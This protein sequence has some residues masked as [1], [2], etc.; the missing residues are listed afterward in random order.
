MSGETVVS[1]SPDG[2]TSPATYT[3]MSRTRGEFL[4]SLNR[5]LGTNPSDDDTRDEIEAT[6]NAVASLRELHA[7]NRG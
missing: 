4:R 2:K 1:C 3:Q 6:I 7:G 5:W